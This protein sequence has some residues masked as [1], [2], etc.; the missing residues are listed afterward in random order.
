MGDADVRYIADLINGNEPDA[1]SQ[2]RKGAR[3]PRRMSTQSAGDFQSGNAGQDSENNRESRSR[4]ATTNT[5]PSLSP[6]ADEEGNKYNMPSD[7]ST[8]RVLH[9]ATCDVWVPSRSGDWEV[10]IAGIRHRRHVLSLREYGE[11]G[12][13]VLSAFESDPR[14]GEV[15]HRVAGKASGTEFGLDQ[16]ASGSGSGFSRKQH[17]GGGKKNAQQQADPE[18]PTLQAMHRE[19]VTRCLGIYGHGRV[20]DSVVDKFVTIEDLGRAKARSD[21]RL[22]QRTLYQTIYKYEIINHINQLRKDSDGPSDLFCIAQQLREG[23]QKQREISK[24]PPPATTHAGAGGIKKQRDQQARQAQKRFLLPP[25][26]VLDM[27]YTPNR[28][29]YVAAWMC[30]LQSFIHALAEHPDQVERLIIVLHCD[31]PEHMRETLQKGWDR[32]LLDMENVLL[33]KN[34]KLKEISFY[35]IADAFRE[36]FLDPEDLEEFG[37][38]VH[39]DTVD[40]NMMEYF[41][42]SYHYL[43][44]RAKETADNVR[45]AILMSQHPRFGRCS[46]LQLLPEAAIQQIVEDAVPKDGCVIRVNYVGDSPRFKYKPG[47]WTFRDVEP[48][49]ERYGLRGRDDDG[50]DDE[51]GEDKSS[52]EEEEEEEEEA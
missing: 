38:N 51:D 6:Q 34:A 1:I 10:H 29:D 42:E 39:D 2:G 37:L 15:S 30:G 17:Q 49:T 11:R 33:A 35:F 45:I 28:S 50:D 25:I 41:D 7:K 26:V 24:Y 27:D 52:E 47:L 16:G 12:R 31:F 8:N 21:Y 23:P 18:S 13:L 20:Y 44:K 14:A 22:A 32:C 5:A 36:A 43:V 19:L 40:S 4:H 48:T 46:L 9:C 3:R